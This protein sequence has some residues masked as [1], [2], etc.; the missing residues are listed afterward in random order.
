MKLFDLT[1]GS[2]SGRVV[3]YLS[4]PASLG[5]QY[6]LEIVRWGAGGITIQFWTVSEP[7]YLRAT[8]DVKMDAQDE[9]V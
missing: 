6:S 2:I 1:Y 8:A 3:D 5:M 4:P 7:V 9:D